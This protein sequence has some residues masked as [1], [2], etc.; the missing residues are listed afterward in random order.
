MLHTY[1]DHFTFELAPF[2]FFNDLLNY[3]GLDGLFPEGRNNFDRVGHFFVGVFAYPL[4]EFV[5]RKKIIKN[6]FVAILFGIFALGF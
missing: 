6:I 2:G 5:Y 3:S 4:A 1:G